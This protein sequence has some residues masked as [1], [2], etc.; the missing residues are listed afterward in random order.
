MS[1]TEHISDSTV[2][3][4]EGIDLLSLVEHRESVQASETTENVYKWF[5]TH[6]Q[7]YV[8]VVSG[9][10]LV[11]MVSRGHIGFLL[12]ARFGFAL[13]GRLPVEQ[14]LMPH[15]LRVN[16][17]TPLLT[18]LDQAL[19]R[20]GDS[21]Y[22]D[23]ALVDE[24]EQ[25]LGIITVPTLVRWQS[26]LISQK[27]ELAEQQRLALHKNNQELF[28]S[29]H[30]LRQSQG[31]FDILFENSAL[32]VALMTPQGEV[33]TGNHRLETLLGCPT[34]APRTFNFSSL[35]VE[36]D[37]EGFLRLLQEH[38][39]NPQEANPRNSEFLLNLPGRGPRR[40][41]FFTNWIRETGQVCA[42]VDDVTEQRVLE[43]RLIQKEKSA[44]LDSLV[45]GIAHEINNKLA[46]II[47]FSELL[48]A[49]LERGQPPEKVARYCTMIRDS[50][51]DSAKIIRQVLQLSRPVTAEFKVCDVRELVRDVTAFLGFRIRESGCEVILDLPATEAWVRVD[52]TQI[53]QVIINL[54]LNALDALE[55]R[56]KKQL[57]LSVAEGK[58]EIILKVADTGQGIKPEYLNYIFDPFFT[59]KS[60]ERGSG[61][62]LSVCLSI[63]RQHDGEISV[64][65][66]WDTGSEFELTLPKASPAAVAQ[67][68]KAV[69]PA[70]GE[71]DNGENNHNG[72]RR[73]VLVVDDEDFITAMIQEVLRGDLNCNVE[74]VTSGLKA[75]A[76]LEQ[77]DFDFVISDVRMPELDGFGLFEWI[78][79]NQPR[80]T[81]RFLFI[82]GDAGSQDL[83]QK[84]ES[85]GAPVLR[86]PFNMDTLLREYQRLAV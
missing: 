33:E 79:Q 58:D 59:T 5:Q 43:H 54:T 7:E 77:T 8:G 75:V 68:S 18:I 46:P 76:R 6:Q 28:R 15:S 50:A 83:N 81:E 84:L 24:E 63:A 2:A 62:G 29:L 53:K 20:Q 72:S 26:K 51:M 35:V 64:K 73:R 67:N 61:L 13:Y 36:P 86:K 12:G 71:G 85:L 16:R 41:K 60:P 11:G 65:S 32:G 3:S 37:W 82:T 78:K 25:F 34:D 10:R 48:L 45:G 19:S 38:E 66:V 39:A 30:Q 56:R 4:V 23:V 17:T 80:L 57:R 47:G 40:F 52:V 49:Q 42:L 14:H 31:K 55:N 69:L 44:M 9:T 74:R 1:E 70:H 27:T 21:F 22:D